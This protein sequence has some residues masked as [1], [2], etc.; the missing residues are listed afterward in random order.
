MTPQQHA[1]SLY[2]RATASLQ[3]GHVSEA[4]AQLLE[5]LKANPRHDA[6]R[7]TLVGLLVEARRP[8]EAMQQ[9]QTGLTLDPR[10]PS[11]AMLLARLQMERGGD[12]IETLQRTLPYA[13]GNGEYHAF[14]AGALQRAQRHREAIDQFQS[15]L[16]A[17]PLNGVWWMG[18]GI[19]LQAEKRLPEAT[20]AFRR[21]KSSGTLSPELQALVDRKLQQLPR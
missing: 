8:E 13:A 17:A 15:A 12:G 14:L 5:A 10:Q 7:Q 21:A 11:M 1:E 18:L 4:M 2:H 3:D 16:R 6:A 9:L 19:S 20:D